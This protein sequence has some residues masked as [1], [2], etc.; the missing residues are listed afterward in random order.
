MGIDLATN[1]VYSYQNTGTNKVVTTLIVKSFESD[2]ELSDNTFK[3][4]QK[5]WEGFEL[6]D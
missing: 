2:L 5:E 4:D 6:N 3:F 1:L